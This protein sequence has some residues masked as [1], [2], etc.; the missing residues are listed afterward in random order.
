M[1][2]K[3]AGKNAPVDIEHILKEND[4]FEDFSEEELHY[5]SRQLSLRSFEA[6]TNLFN[7]GDYGTYLFIVVDGEVE[8]RLDSH[9]FKQMIIATF[10]RGSCVGEMSLIDDYPRSASIVV[11]KPSDLLILSRNRFD[12]ICSESPQVGLKFL[13]GIAQN[14]S[15]R[16]RKTTGRFADLA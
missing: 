12:T 5:F 15:L 9:E 3:T 8:V 11:T 6:G 4:F 16:L 2:Q 10:E 14:L 13:R 1:T 7:K